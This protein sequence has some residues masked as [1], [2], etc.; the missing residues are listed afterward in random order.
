MKK[1]I[2]SAIITI[3]FAGCNNPLNKPIVEPLTVEELRSVSKKDTSFIEF[4]EQIQNFR[5]SF[6]DE[7]INQVKYGDISYK[8]LQKYIA[9]RADSTFTKPIIE[10]STADW[11]EKYG[12][13][14]HELDSLKNYWQNYLEE[15]SLMSYVAIEFDHIDKDY[16]SYN[17]EVKNVNL[18]LR[19]TPLKGTIQQISFTYKIKSKLRSDE[20]ESIYSSIYDDNRGSCITTS[21]FSTS[22]VRYWEV[23]YTLE[24]TLKYMSTAE[25]NRDYNIT[26]EVSKIRV[27]NNNIS[28][29]DL[30]VPSVMEDYLK[31]PSLYE[32]DVIKYFFNPDYISYWEYTSKA[33]DNELRIKDE[34]CYNFIK[35]VYDSDED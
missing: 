35:A 13:Y 14:E 21:P 20:S 5:Q 32:D 33:I 18:A 34:K 12:N 11:N 31:Y 29:D 16:Y 2:Y 24:K 22:V 25:F 8:Q 7:D 10:K 3:L 26:F 19:L 30:L 23:N 6:F 17:N 27:N 15:N 28:E 1:F 4:Y 9:Y